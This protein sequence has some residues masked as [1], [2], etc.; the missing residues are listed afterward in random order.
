MAGDGTGLDRDESKN[1]K[2]LGNE[3]KVGDKVKRVSHPKVRSGCLTCKQRR[4]KCD[5]RMPFCFRC[6]KFGVQCDGYLRTGLSQAETAQSRT[7]NRPLIPRKRD[8]SPFPEQVRKARFRNYDEMRYFRLFCEKTSLQLS[9]YYDPILWGR[10]VLQASEAEDSIR[11]AVISIGAL[12]MTA[13]M[14]QDS[15]NENAKE[16]H[17]FALKQYGEAIRDMR[18]MAQRQKEMHNLQHALVASILIICFEVKK[19]TLLVSQMHPELTELR[20]IMGIM[21]QLPS[22]FGPEFV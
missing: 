22:K 11:H 9:G 2:K 4:V 20:H 18:A 19:K 3:K 15:K 7:T 8:A 5:E 14:M 21:L 17:L 16:H 1:E 10:I 12:D 13:A 6:E